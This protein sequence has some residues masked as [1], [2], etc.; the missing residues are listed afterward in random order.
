M[1]FNEIWKAVNNGRGKTLF[2]KQG[3]FQPARLQNNHIE[4]IPPDQS[5]DA[6]IDDIIDEMIEINLQH[7]GDSVFVEG[8][9]LEKF[10]G[11]VLITKN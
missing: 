11:L 1:D 9:Q 3:Y 4:L 6:N 10:N 8:N 7:E 2:V 5:E